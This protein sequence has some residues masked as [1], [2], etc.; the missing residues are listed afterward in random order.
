[1]NAQD[2]SQTLK[3]LFPVEKPD[4]IQGVKRNRSHDQI[5]RGQ[6]HGRSTDA[7]QQIFSLR[8]FGHRKASAALARPCADL[9]P[10]LGVHCRTPALPLR[11]SGP[12][13]ARHLLHCDLDPH[14]RR[15][16]GS[17]LSRG[18]AQERYH[19]LPENRHRHCRRNR[20]G[21]RGVHRG[22]GLDSLACP[23]RKIAPE[24]AF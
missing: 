23:A 6:D 15:R 3:Q 10:H 21:L 11:L 4:A 17:R 16:G 8:R 1:M 14:R 24:A 22:D 12:K 5:S 2:G 7:G 18:A 20:W 19:G 13:S 9:W